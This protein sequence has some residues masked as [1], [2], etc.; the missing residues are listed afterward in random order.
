MLY[1]YAISVPCPCP[2]PLF[3]VLSGPGHPQTQGEEKRGGEIAQTAGGPQVLPRSGRMCDT[4]SKVNQCTINVQKYLLL[5]QNRSTLFLWYS[6]TVQATTQHFLEEL[7]ARR[8]VNP[9]FV[10]TLAKGVRLR[11]S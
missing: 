9:R 7:F 4:Q 3:A 11:F 6:K 2:S 10:E 8:C 5:V 1:V